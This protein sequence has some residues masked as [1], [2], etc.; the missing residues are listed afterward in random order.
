MK[1]EGVTI[2]GKS[3]FLYNYLSVVLNRL[4]VFGFQLDF[5]L[6]LDFVSANALICWLL[7]LLIGGID[8]Q[9]YDEFKIQ[10]HFKYILLFSN[11]LR[12]NRLYLSGINL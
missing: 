3:Q 12:L 5:I 7:E 9:R 1:F 10:C 8:K 2:F 11:I 6:K 4:T